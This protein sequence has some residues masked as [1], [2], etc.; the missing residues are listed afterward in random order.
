MQRAS[1]TSP[2]GSVQRRLRVEPTHAQVPRG[3]G[4]AAVQ[5][6]LL[7][8]QALRTR[9]NAYRRISAIKATATAGG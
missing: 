4:T 3:R 9:S 2:A 8:S 7:N 5:F 6:Q 1:E